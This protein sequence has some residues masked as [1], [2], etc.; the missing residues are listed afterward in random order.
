M[1]TSGG[2]ARKC[3]CSCENAHRITLVALACTVDC[4]ST[5]ALTPAYGRRGCVQGSSGTLN[6]SAN[7]LMSSKSI[8][9]D[10]M[11]ST[12]LYSQHT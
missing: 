12:R 3:Y 8:D 1:N 7:Q 5:S 11:Q 4:P 6:P 10:V 2:R 9:K